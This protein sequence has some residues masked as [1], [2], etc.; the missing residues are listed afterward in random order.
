MRLMTANDYKIREKKK[1]EQQGK[2][3]VSERCSDDKKVILFI[4]KYKTTINI[5]IEIKFLI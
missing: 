1:M 4:Y 2:K 3:K 5:I